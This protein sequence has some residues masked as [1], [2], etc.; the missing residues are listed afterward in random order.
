MSQRGKPDLTAQRKKSKQANTWCPRTEESSRKVSKGRREEVS[1]GRAGP[2][3]R[4]VRDERGSEAAPSP[5]QSGLQ[6]AE[7]R[8]DRGSALAL[9]GGSLVPFL[10]FPPGL[11]P[12]LSALITGGAAGDREAS[13]AGPASRSEP[14]PHLVVLHVPVGPV[15][16]Q[17]KRRL[18]VVD[19]RCPVESGFSCKRYARVSRLHRGPVPAPR[20]RK[21]VPRGV[22]GPTPSIPPFP[23]S[24]NTACR[25]L[26]LQR[27]S[28]D[29]AH[30][31]VVG[32]PPPIHRA[33]PT[34]LPR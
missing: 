22:Q 23:R 11:L 7:H 16:Q 20:I 27:T 21:S 6:P 8:A 24:R 9:P 26:R 14:R 10:K 4:E 3:R 32:L 12:P 2:G 29:W 33:E 17:Q 5:V 34:L 19:S 28:R 13:D 1:K 25:L 18:H 15:F 30:L 31:S